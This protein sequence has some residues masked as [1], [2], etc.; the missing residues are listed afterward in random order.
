MKD[1][2]IENGRSRVTVHTSGGFTFVN[3][4]DLHHHRGQVYERTLPELHASLAAWEVPPGMDREPFETVRAEV[5]AR[6]KQE[7]KPVL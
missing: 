1:F 4:W 3:I 6:I 7:T 5:L 2:Q